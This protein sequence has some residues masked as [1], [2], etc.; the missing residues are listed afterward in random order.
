VVF[1]A[2]KG[3]SE[4]CIHVNIPFS[5]CK[6]HVLPIPG[7][8]VILVWTGFSLSSLHVALMV[9]F[10]FESTMPKHVAK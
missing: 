4:D 10:P 8:N 1:I 7:V 3:Q 6:V 2:V 5:F 9:Q